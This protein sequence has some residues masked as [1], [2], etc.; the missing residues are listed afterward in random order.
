MLTFKSFVCAEII[1]SY[2]VS[3]IQV[4]SASELNTNCE[5]GFRTWPGQEIFRKGV[6]E[7]GSSQD[8]S[9]IMREKEEHGDIWQDC[10]KNSK[11]LQTCLNAEWALFPQKQEHSR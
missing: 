1:S 9:N 6:I 8:N 4:S 11:P 2:C 3:I 5:A 7:Y 10:L